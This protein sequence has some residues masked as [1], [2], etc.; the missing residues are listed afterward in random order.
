MR[1]LLFLTI[2][3]SFSFTSCCTMIC[4]PYQSVQISSN[5]PGSNVTIDGYPMGVTPLTVKLEQKYSHQVEIEK[6]GF[7]SENY[8]I[9]S[10]TNPIKLA[11]NAI[12][13]G[14]GLVGLGVGAV[15]SGGLPVLFFLPPIAL[16]G[17]GVGTVTSIAGTATDLCTGKAR[18][19]SSDR[20]HA[21]LKPFS[22]ILEK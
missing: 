4:D 17:F 12:P 14:I 19:L 8:E 3:S 7:Y 16:V 13:F 18:E 22:L 20:V 6:E 9:K 2:L 10:Q 15:A 21:N 5:P 11:S 1:N